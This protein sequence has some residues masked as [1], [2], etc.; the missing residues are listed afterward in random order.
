MAGMEINEQ[1]FHDI[2]LNLMVTFAVL[3]RE[4]SVTR[5]AALLNVG[6]PAVSGALARLRLHFDDPLFLRTRR[7]VR[8]TDRAVEIVQLLMPALS[9]IE[10]A[11]TRNRRLS[12][13]NP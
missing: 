8:P 2:D 7:G 6:Q 4:L 1:N 9:R 13:L 10:T 3:F 12:P 11:I 5:T